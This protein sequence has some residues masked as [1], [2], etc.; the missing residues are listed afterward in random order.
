MIAPLTGGERGLIRIRTVF[1]DF[2]VIFNK[3]ES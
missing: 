3:E 1:L 2:K